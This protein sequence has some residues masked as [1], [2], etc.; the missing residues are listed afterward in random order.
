MTSLARQSLATR[1]D[2]LGIRPW[3]MDEDLIERVRE[4]GLGEG[5]VAPWLGP[6]TLVLGSGSKAE[7]EANLGAAVSDGV[8]IQRRRGGGCA[9]VLDRGNLIVSAVVPASGPA[10]IRGRFDRFS[11]WVIEGLGRLGLPV[12]ERREVSDLCLGDRKI[13]GAALYLER[14]LAYYT[15]TLLHSPALHYWERYLPHPPREPAYRRGRSHAEF[16]TSL[17]DE[18]GMTALELSSRLAEALGPVP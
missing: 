3:T 4:T 15:T 5:R 8:P 11:S 13:G 12:A 10:S 17:G 2:V 1:D 7:V 16:V 18:T 14:G 9:V 6:V